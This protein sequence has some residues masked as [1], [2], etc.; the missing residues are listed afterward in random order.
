MFV[1]L[2]QTI[3]EVPPFEAYGI[4]SPPSLSV[5]D[6]RMFAPVSASTEGPTDKSLRVTRNT[7]YPIQAWYCICLFIFIIAVFQ[8]ISFFHSKLASL[9]RSHQ[10][11]H[12]S[13]PEQVTLHRRHAFSWRRIP[14]GLANAFRVIAFRWTLEFGNTYSLTI[15]EVLVTM[16]Y[17]VF[18]FVWA[19]FNSKLPTDAARMFSEYF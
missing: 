5:M 4:S 6:G 7:L 2:R 13:D 9:Q 8:W 3:K 12:N 1:L 11:S 10:T 18:I 17:I 14:L 16:A 15:V 19:F